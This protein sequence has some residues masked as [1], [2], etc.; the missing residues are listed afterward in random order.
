MHHDLLRIGTGPY[1][2]PQPDST[3]YK[4]LRGS[5]P[6]AALHW[7]VR[8]FNGGENPRY[9]ARSLVRFAVEEVSIADPNAL[10]QALAG[11]EAYERLGAPEGEAG[12]RIICLPSF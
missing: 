1:S 8:M 9:I 5:H 2:P 7:F 10:T 6:D 11:W 4:S 12:R 3:L